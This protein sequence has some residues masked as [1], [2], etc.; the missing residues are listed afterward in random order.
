MNL[1]IAAC[2]V[3]VC[4]MVSGCSSPG[5]FRTG[6]FPQSGRVLEVKEFD[7]GLFLPGSDSLSPEGRSQLSAFLNQ[8]SRDCEIGVDVWGDERSLALGGKHR[9]SQVV[10]LS[11]VRANAIVDVLRASG[12][13]AAWAN[14]RGL[15]R[16]NEQEADRRTTLTVIASD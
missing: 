15:E 10:R 11:V 8:L 9:D 16:E 3:L 14:G 12:H 13:R 4:A 5:A 2:G 1:L 6:I 7:G